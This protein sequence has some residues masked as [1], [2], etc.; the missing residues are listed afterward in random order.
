LTT[1]HIDLLQSTG[2]KNTA[3]QSTMHLNNNT[4]QFQL[5]FH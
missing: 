1:F 4:K 5:K 2:N 3:P